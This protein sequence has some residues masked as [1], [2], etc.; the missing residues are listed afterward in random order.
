MLQRKYQSLQINLHRCQR[1][2]LEM[3]N[4]ILERFGSNVKKL[5]IHGPS[6]KIHRDLLEILEQMPF[7]EELSVYHLN[8]R[9]NLFKS[10][11]LPGSFELLKM[12][13][14]KKIS[15]EY[16]DCAILYLFEEPQFN[17]FSIRWGRL[18]D[19]K[20]LDTLKKSKQLQHLKLCDKSYENLPFNDLLDAP[21]KL[22]SLSVQIPN[23]Y[24]E[25]FCSHHYNRTLFDMTS[26][27]CKFLD[28]QESL[29]NFSLLN[30]Y[31]SKVENSAWL[32][33]FEQIFRKLN[34]FERLELLCLPKDRNTFD[35]ML[36]SLTMKTLAIHD[37]LGNDRNNAEIL[38]KNCPNLEN[39]ETFECR[40]DSLIELFPFMATHNKK[41][42]F[43]STRLNLKVAKVKFESLESVEIN[44]I[45]NEEF[46]KT[47]FEFIE[48]NP[49]V[50][51][52]AFTCCLAWETCLAVFKRILTIATVK[53]FVLSGASYSI[54]DAY[55]EV[56]FDLKNLKSLELRVVEHGN[57]HEAFA[58]SGKLLVSLPDDSSKWDP[59]LVTILT[60]VSSVFFI[61]FF[62]HR[63]SSTGIYKELLQSCSSCIYEI[64]CVLF[65]QNTFIMK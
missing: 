16:S 31:E 41:L 11:P 34:Q 12:Q 33:V 19:E 62:Y 44:S 54:R 52:V 30:L 5:E 1:S 39:Y 38:L 35:K 13:N 8:Y 53:H 6:F 49:T 28:L 58:Y 63:Q 21:F 27:L 43:F 25:E 48:F 7:L 24:S 29:K 60:F 56:K 36:P 20:T 17:F 51:K 22:L 26:C 57:S 47:F 3:L 15:I 64:F 46:L 65:K 61:L 2:D 14:L 59:N 37:G 40:Q 32:L 18:N 4:E 50:K 55:N 10:L 23:H 45:E 9:E 42:K